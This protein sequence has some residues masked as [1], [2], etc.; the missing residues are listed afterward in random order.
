MARVNGLNSRTYKYKSVLQIVYQ[1]FDEN[2]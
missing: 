1:G 2:T